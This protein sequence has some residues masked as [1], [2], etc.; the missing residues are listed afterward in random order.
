MHRQRSVLRPL[1]AL[2]FFG[3]M[4]ALIMTACGGSTPTNVPD[5][6]QLI[7]KAQAAIQ[8]VTSY[9]FNLVVDHPGTNG[10][11]TVQKADGDILIPD[12]LKANAN[13]LVLGSAASVQMVSVG[14]QQYVTDPISNQWQKTSGLLDPRTLSDSKTGVASILGHMQNLSTPTA[15]SVDGTPCWSI[16]GKLDAQY[17]SSITGGGAPTGSTIAVTTCI[18]KSDN[19]PYLIKMTGVAS[20]GDNTNTVRNFK[21]SKFNESITI[22]APIS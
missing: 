22:T 2:F 4:L 3:L 11:F 16:D 18:G 1:P 8:K 9:H 15:S 7:T 10:V 21:L 5:A 20:Q 19:L 6:H 17:L 13:I 14:S 12:K